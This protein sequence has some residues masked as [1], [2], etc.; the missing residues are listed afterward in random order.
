MNCDNTVTSYE[1]KMKTMPHLNTIRALN[2]ITAIS[3]TFAAHMCYSQGLPGT[4]LKPGLWEQT[5]IV[6]VPAGSEM[7]KR[8]AEMDATHRKLSEIERKNFEINQKISGSYWSPLGMAVS[9]QFC[10]AR[11]TVQRCTTHKLPSISANGIELF[12][13]CNTFSRDSGLIR[14]DRLE[15]DGYEAVLEKLSDA[16]GKAQN[17]VTRHS[18]K[19]ISKECG[20]TRPIDN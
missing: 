19:Y 12:Y 1:L 4:T 7:A 17:A 10:L 8:H 5:V 16:F 2:A 15:D 18:M 13:I 6:D 14:F 20:K 9:S 3:F 11:Q